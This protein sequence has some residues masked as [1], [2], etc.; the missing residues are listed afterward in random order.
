V[1]EGRTVSDGHSSRPRGR[2]GLRGARRFLAVLASVS[3]ASAFTVTAGAASEVPATAWVGAA[4]IV[5][6]GAARTGIMPSGATMRFDV[7]LNPRNGAALTQLVNDISTPGSPLYHHYLTHSQFVALFGPTTATVDRVIATLRARGLNPGAVS[8][9]HLSISVTATAAQVDS[10]FGVSM[11][12]YRLPGGKVG[13]ANAGTIKV[14]TSVA[15]VVQAVIGLD[16]LN[17]PQP[18]L[19]APS[20]ASGTKGLHIKTSTAAV[21]AVGPK[22][23][24]AV[25]EA[26]AGDSFPS[27]N[28]SQLAYAYEFDGL[29]SGHDLGRGVSVGIVEFNEPDLPSDIAT[30][31]KCYGTHA[32]VSYVHV[33]GFRRKGPGHGEAA[34][35]IEVMVSMAPDAHVYVYQAPNNG[36]STYDDYRAIVNQHKVRVI[37]ESYGLCEYYQDRQEAR[38][39]TTLFKEAAAQG[40]TIV[41]SSG[42]SG[43]QG[44]LLENGRPRQLSVEWPASD[45]YVLGVGGTA[46]TKLAKRPGEVVWNDGYDGDGAGGGGKSVIYG[47]PTY[48]KKYGIHSDHVREVPDVSAD[49]DPETG[50][51]TFHNHSWGIIGG[52]SAAAPLWA[53]LL[54][55]TDAK[56]PREPLGWS[57]SAIYYAASKHM[58]TIVINDIRAFPKVFPDNTNNNYIFFKPGHLYP[59]L[60]GYDAATGLGSPVGVKLAD[61]LCKINKK[62]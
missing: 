12:D 10:A 24:S 21:P 15:G 1:L 51:I 9:D 54:T 60:K 36:V 42:D 35:D 50:Y 17:L 6:H 3:A 33:D 23:C 43:A 14:P 18:M 13:F 31:Q 27:Y 37:S 41:V 40:Q 32:K 38:A 56:C 39:V 44:C 62:R 5:P 61:T 55:L 22:A 57:N 2:R 59:V 8:S 48:Q 47:E 49:A 16:N 30:F 29:F 52:T 11:T 20:P 19:T 7:V 58:K 45:P 25:L 53:A 4:G 46:I 34:L 28:M 26:Q